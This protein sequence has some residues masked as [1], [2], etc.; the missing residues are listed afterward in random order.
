M[1]GRRFFYCDVAH[2]EKTGNIVSTENGL[3][4]A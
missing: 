3:W 1:E 4:T 2:N